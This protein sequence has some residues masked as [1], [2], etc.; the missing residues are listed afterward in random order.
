M[1]VDSVFD[2][3]KELQDITRKQA[4]KYS[5]KRA[6][7]FDIF[8][9]GKS[10]IGIAGLRG[11]GKTTILKQR[12]LENSRAMYIALDSFPQIKLFELAKELK[13]KYAIEELLLDE[14]H[15]Y[16]NWQLEL[17]KIYDFLDLKIYFTSSVAIDIINSKAD[18]SRRV[19]VRAVHPF[20][21]SEY[22][23]FKKNITIAKISFKDIGAV[24]KL[25]EIANQDH[26]FKDYIFGGL[27]PAHLEEPSMD[28]FGNII[29]KIV[30][31]DLVYARKFSGEDIQNI[32]KMLEYIAN[33]T[34]EDTSYSSI[35]RNLGITKYLAI[36]YV[37]A[38]EQ[39]YILNVILPKGSNVTKEPKIL[40]VPPFRY[41]FLKDKSYEKSIGAFREEFFV[42]HMKIFGYSLNYLKGRRGEKKPDYIVY[43]GA[44]KY[45]FEIGGKNKTRTQIVKGQEKNKFILVQP[46]NLR[47]FYRPLVA[48]GF[49]GK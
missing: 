23:L 29:E 11:A 26:N 4:Q 32:R 12:L 38:L 20:S 35:S 30:E 44:E 22:L 14:I 31:K 18:L 25:V 40:F 24:E 41:Y 5:K 36:K 6:C 9:A 2:T 1:V 28:I 19:I 3:L 46:S 39:A 49:L 13:E 43:V 47:G 16:A 8:K 33:A 37:S 17:K 45:I 48:I 7:Y 27:L 21:F 34:I 42:E 15:Y 10:F